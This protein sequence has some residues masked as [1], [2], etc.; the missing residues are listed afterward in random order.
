MTKLNQD[1]LSGLLFIVVGIAGLWFGK[2]LAVGT[3]FRM[4]PGY[5]PMVLCSLLVLIGLLIALK[6]LVKSTE[7]PGRLH[8]RP[9]ILVTLS[10]LAFAGL[11]ENAGLLPAAFAVVLIATCGGPEF[12]WLEGLLLAVVLSLGAVGL[13][14]FALNMTIPIINY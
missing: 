5:F 6:G 3:A 1:V 4:G 13:F 8:W 7:M 14:I 2:D 9:L 10:I 12:H 11:I